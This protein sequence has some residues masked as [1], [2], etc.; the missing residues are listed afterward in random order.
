MNN[1]LKFLCRRILLVLVVVC[2]VSSPAC[3]YGREGHSNDWE[4]CLGIDAAATGN[5][6][7]DLWKTAQEIIDQYKTEE[8]NHYRKIKEEFPWFSW[9]KYNHR[10]LFHW[11]FNNDPKQHDPLV[12]QARKT[13][14]DY[15]DELNRRRNPTED[16][17][18]FLKKYGPKD[19]QDSELE[20]FY[21]YLRNLQGERNSR[22]IKKVV[23]VTGIPTA[24]GHANAL[25]TLIYD[26][27]M[28][29]DYESAAADARALPSIERLEKDILELG[30]S[31]LL[32]GRQG[33]TG[34]EK[35]REL[36]EA[37]KSAAKAG[38]GLSYKYRARKL[39]EALAE[40]LP[41]VL[42]RKFVHT[43]NSNGIYLEIQKENKSQEGSK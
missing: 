19:T 4:F 15:V 10:L 11:G 39:R 22:L 18:A 41:Q 7:D 24:R 37:I 43:L 36:Y 21:K 6:M 12:T 14:A 35:D 26:I 2:V 13:F 27:H 31:R 28:L 5:K 20:R 32:Y 25:A 33:H 17:E 3:G 42:N 38:R 8:T 29:G 30:F 34:D 9:G 23:D 40:Y 1:F 16:E